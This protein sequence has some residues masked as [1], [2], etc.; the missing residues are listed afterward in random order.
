MH[1]DPNFSKSSPILVMFYFLKYYYYCVFV[2]IITIL[3]GRMWYFIMVLIS[4]FKWLVML[5][6]FCVIVVLCKFFSRKTFINIFAHSLN[7]LFCSCCNRVLYIVWILTPISLRFA[8]I[9]SHFM[10]CLF[11]LF[12][13][14][15][16][17]YSV[18]STSF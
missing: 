7:R 11:T 12:I 9:F 15:M 16:V 8:N 17:C 5:T 3:M 18:Y 14:S 10:G 1:E 4:F 13:V 2:L 6:S